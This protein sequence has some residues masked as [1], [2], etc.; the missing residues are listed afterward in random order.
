M[1]P[2]AVDEP[3]QIRPEERTYPPAKIFPMKETRF[4]KF[5]EP[6]ADGYRKAF[7][8]GNAA[9]VIDNGKQEGS[10]CGSDFRAQ[11]S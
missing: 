3:K 7:E 2:S 8:H 1:A 9:I 4:E 5:I 6:Q 11:L 10:S